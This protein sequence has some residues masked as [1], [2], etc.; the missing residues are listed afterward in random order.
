MRYPKECVLKECV[1]AV[2]RP[3][4]PGDR[5]LMEAFYNRIP[6][7]DRW[8]MNY[9]VM[10]PAIMG[11]WFDAVEKGSVC[12]ILALCEETVVGQ[13][14]LYLRGF[15]ATSH[16]G[17]FRIVV[18][19][20]FRQMRL[21]TWLLL[22]LIQL[23]MD[24]GLEMLRADLVAGV[25]DGAIE[26]VQ[27]FDF[28]KFAELKNYVKDIHGNRQDLVIMIKRLHKEWSDF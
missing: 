3:L 20:E 7:S 27:K 17:R 14:S 1:E 9:D 2:I 11:R 5:A 15:G 10:D 19:P 18:L 21:G 12:S 13:G 6:E 26:A 16:V 25:E 4:E 8:F 22:D 28:F 23:A 24:R